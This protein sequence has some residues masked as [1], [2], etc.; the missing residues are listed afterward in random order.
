VTETPTPN[1]PTSSPQHS[2][3][4]GSTGAPSAGDWVRFVVLVLLWGTAFVFIKFGV[5]D[6]APA[7][8]TVVR[9]WAS[10]AL[11]TVWALARGH[12]LPRIFPRPDPVWR[13]HFA[14]GFLGAALPFTIIAVGQTQVPSALAGVIIAIMPLAT[15]AMARLFISN[16]RLSARKIAGFAIGFVGVVVLIGPSALRDLGGPTTLAQLAIMLGA[17]SYAATGIVAYHAPKGSATV[18]AA[19]MILAAAVLATPLGLMEIVRHPALT[20]QALLAA[21]ALGLGASGIA[22]IVYLQLVRSA[23]PSFSSLANYLVPITAIAAGVTVGE[24]LDPSVFIAF[25]IILAGVWLGARPG[26]Q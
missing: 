19:C 23:G 5:E 15:A 12:R 18:G 2:D 21:L 25:A 26:R 20:G 7:Y 4:P 10:A 6:T 24:R 8:L 1:A 13:W 14:L 3:A 16:E 9:L 17:L 22:T 11:L